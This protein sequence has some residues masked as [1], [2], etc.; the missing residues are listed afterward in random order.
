MY[1]WLMMKNNKTY[2]Q[3]LCELNDALHYMNVSELKAICEHYRL[4][5]KATKALLIDLIMHF[6][7]TG[8]VKKLPRMPE[9]S[10]AKKGELYPL[11]IDTK[12][13][14]GSYKND[15][16]T[17]TFFK[18]L[19]G[20]H[21]HFTAFGIDWL[22]SCWLAGSPPTYG[23]FA[24]FWQSEYEAQKI[25]K[26]P[27]KKEWAYINFVQKLLRINPHIAKDDVMQAWAKEREMHVDKVKKILKL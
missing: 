23:D 24:Q 19:I 4:P 11:K 12:M 22:N 9:M 13:L 8:D 6:V 18:S 7:Q 14:H 15:A 5:A 21:F 17:R 26:S 27:P 16:Q 25:Q 1:D 2:N 10:K 20:D 3:D